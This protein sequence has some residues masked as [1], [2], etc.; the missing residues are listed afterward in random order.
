MGVV[1]ALAFALVLHHE[2]RTHRRGETGPLPSVR[3]SADAVTG[4]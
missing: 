2:H 3:G 4:S 1:G